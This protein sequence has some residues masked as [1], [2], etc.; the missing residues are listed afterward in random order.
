MR[1]LSTFILI[2]IAL[3]SCNPLNKSISEELTIADIKSYSEKDSIFRETYIFVENFKKLTEDD[4]LL[5]A[6]YSEVT[7]QDIYDYKLFLYDS[8]LWEE[9]EIESNNKRDDFIKINFPLLR[10]M[11]E[12]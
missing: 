7:Y 12:D 11:E 2:F 9:K 10:E 3:S 8:I 6:K 5:S 1:N 4:K